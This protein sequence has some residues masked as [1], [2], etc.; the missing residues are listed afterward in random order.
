MVLLGAMEE[1]FP[2]SASWNESNTTTDQKYERS[3]MQ[4][5]KKRI[6]VLFVLEKKLE[7]FIGPSLIIS[8]HQVFASFEV[9][10]L[11]LSSRLTPWD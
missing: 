1:A 7:Q 9:L 11:S 10:K 2:L 4:E 8:T 3:K 5:D 6:L